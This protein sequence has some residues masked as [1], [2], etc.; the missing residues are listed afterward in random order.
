MKKRDRII[1]G[2][3]ALSV[4]FFCGSVIFQKYNTNP[5]SIT[6]NALE[7]YGDLTYIIG[8]NG[9]VKIIDC[10]ESATD[11][12]IP[13]EIDGVAVTSIE[14]NAFEYCLKLE[15][16][17]IP[18]SV[19]SIGDYAFSKCSAL[20]SVEIPDSVTSIGDEAFAFCKLASVKIP[21]GIESINRFTFSYCTEL[22]SIVIPD[23]VTDIASFAFGNCE[24]LAEIKFSENLKSIGSDAFKNCKNLKN[25]TLPESLTN[26]GRE[27]FYGC[28]ELEEITILNPECHIYD[29]IE[30]ISE[31]ATICGYENST[32][33]E[34]A[35]KYNYKFK[36]LG[37]IPPQFA[38]TTTTT[39]VTKATTYA[40]KTTTT[41]TP[42][43]PKGDMN[44]DGKVDAVDASVILSYY[45]Y[46]STKPEAE[47]TM[48]IDEFQATYQE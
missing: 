9:T 38:T 22:T 18:D 21:D 30:T 2:F 34:F 3:T 19:T 48:D 7:T 11:I 16:V 33:Q 13:N 8:N 10:D 25:I 44:G 40:P 1:A 4:S 46:L 24:N 37:E 27:A 45:A 17:V 12:V 29:G 32:A 36:S 43:T 6:A 23:S 35:E 39:Y 28:I 42:A 5:F 15:S 26:I 20:K 14:K 41:T 47:A 31:T